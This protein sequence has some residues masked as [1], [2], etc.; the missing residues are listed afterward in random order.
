MEIYHIAVQILQSG[1]KWLTDG[2]IDIPISVCEAS[3]AKT[4]TLMKDVN[5][6]LIQTAYL[7]MTIK[8]CLQVEFQE[9]VTYYNL[10][11][12]EIS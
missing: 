2:L 1:P 8:P 12:F 3:K 9:A 7:K 5:I 4:C 6:P 11:K 10:F